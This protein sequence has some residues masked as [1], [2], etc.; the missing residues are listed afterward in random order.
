MLWIDIFSQSHRPTILDI[1]K[2]LSPQ[3]M[4]LLEDLNNQLFYKYHIK[5]TRPNYSKKSGWV[6]PYRLQGLTLSLLI[7]QNETSFTIAN[8]IIQDESGVQCALAEIDQRCQSGFL[9]KVKDTVAARKERAKGRHTLCQEAAVCK[10][11]P[12]LRGSDPEKLNKFRWIPALPPIKLRQLYR[13]S[14]TGILDHDLLEEV[15][16]L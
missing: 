11:E 2:Y 5:A 13:S 7:I 14:A 16:L 3:T 8:T 1:R 6:F 15:R 4:V 12:T 10:P 9:Q